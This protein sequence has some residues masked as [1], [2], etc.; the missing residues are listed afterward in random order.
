MHHKV[1]HQEDESKLVTPKK[2]TVNAPRK[3]V[4]QLIKQMSLLTRDDPAYG[5][6]Y[7]QAKGLDPDI[8][9]IV[10]K[11]IVKKSY[12]PRS[13]YSPQTPQFTNYQPTSNSYS[14]TTNVPPPVSQPQP[15]PQ[16]VPTGPPRGSE[17]ICWGCGEKGHLMSS[18]QI[19][20][21][22]L[23]NGSLSKDRSGRII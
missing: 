20:N 21:N 9:N 14:G 3:E 2:R 17:I 7:Y 18:C 15:I 4:E 13:N 19:I 12:P 1:R 23:Q 6:A 5:L 10:S 8:V 11:P 22:L 16:N